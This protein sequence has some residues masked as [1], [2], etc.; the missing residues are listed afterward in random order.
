MKIAYCIGFYDK[1]FN[2]REKIYAEYFSQIK[3]TQ[4]YILTSNLPYPS[5]NKTNKEIGA[6]TAK[7][8]NI[9]V[10]RRRPL[11]K[12]RDIIFFK[13]KKIITQIKP[14]IVHVFDSRQFVTYKIAQFAYNKNI[15]VIYDHEQRTEGSTLR[16]EIRS[17]L[18]NDKWTRK[19]MRCCSAINVATP[20]A[21]AYL[22]KLD[23]KSEN[24][25]SIMPLCYDKR[26][27]YYDK[28][29]YKSFRGKYGIQNEKIIIGT[30]GKFS[31]NKRLEV[32]I[33]AFN[34]T[35]RNDC[36]LFI[37]GEIEQEY[38]QKLRT[39]LSKNKRI[40]FSSRLFNTIELNEFFNGID[41]G[42]WTSPTISFFEAIGT[43]LQIII[44]FGSATKH[45]HSNNVTF[46]G[47]CGGIDNDNFIN[48]NLKI[49]SEMMNI[50]SSLTKEYS[51]N[52]ENKYEKNE[53][54]IELEKKY[55]DLINRK[56]S[57]T[58]T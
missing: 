20:G 10:I 51:R 30:S 16:G 43:G 26:S 45:L 14:D 6:G 35:N 29:L 24:K 39:Q 23:S 28:F 2:Y 52:V 49:K 38:L 53:V 36:L 31:K 8:G 48:D 4:V 9:T 11:L 13:F 41:Y 17:K 27:F 7:E 57:I 42:I 47:R 18:C 34:E 37:V 19:T 22:M 5:L 50:F 12:L 21:K 54:L 58:C 56:I 3:E 33:E 15:P 46:Y 32:I 55:L 44:P 1:D 40:I 25:I